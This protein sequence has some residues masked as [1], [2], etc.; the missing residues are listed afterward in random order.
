MKSFPVCASYEHL[1]CVTTDNV[2]I[3]IILSSFQFANEQ[4]IILQFCAVAMPV[5]AG[6]F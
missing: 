1:S 2:L 3:K 6:L 4:N 5:M